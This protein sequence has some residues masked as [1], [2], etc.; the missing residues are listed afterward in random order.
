MN[1]RAELW[2]PR[3]GL[4]GI[5]VEAMIATPVLDAWDRHLGEIREALRDALQHSHGR[6]YQDTTGD[7]GR[8]GGKGLA[9]ALDGDLPKRLFN[10]APG[11]PCKSDAG[12]DH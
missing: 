10:E 9:A 4:G 7:D 5:L 1:S 11:E 6:T 2:V 8:C 12:G 3:R